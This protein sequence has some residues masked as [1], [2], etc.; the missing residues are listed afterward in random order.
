[1]NSEL[2]PTALINDGGNT[3]MSEAKETG[4]ESAANEEL[5]VEI[6][7]PED[8]DD[9]TAPGVADQDVTNAND[10]TACTVIEETEIDGTAAEQ[11]NSRKS[12]A[13]QNEIAAALDGDVFSENENVDGD[14][15]LADLHSF[16]RRAKSSKE[17]KDVPASAMILPPLATSSLTKK[18]PSGSLGSATSENGSPVS[19]I[20]KMATTTTT[21]MTSPR[22]PLGQKDANKSPSPSKKRKLKG[23]G[24]PDA[25]APLTKKSGGRLV[26]PDLEDYG[27][28]APAQ[29]KKRRRKI[30]AD[31]TGDIFNPDMFPSQ[32][33]TKRTS[34]SSSSAPDRD[35]GSASRRSSRIA[36]VKKT[37]AIP[38]RLPG[39]ATLDLGDMPAPSTATVTAR[40][41]DR[42]LAAQTRA[43]TDKN[44]G[45][46]MPVAFVLA[47]LGAA[48]ADED[49]QQTASITLPKTGMKSVRW[50]E[51]LARVQG[52]EMPAPA[53]AE[54]GE[55]AADEEE[56]MALPPPPQLRFASDPSDRPGNP[57]GGML[58]NEDEE[59]QGKK[60]A[61]AALSPAPVRR[62]ARSAA[63]R[64]PT[65]GGSATPVKKKS[66]L[67]S[68]GPGSVSKPSAAS[69]TEARARLGMAGP[70]TPGPRRGG[71]RR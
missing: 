65:R 64:L 59:E 67:P 1:M 45:G 49:D 12:D 38:V 17:R 43:N 69:A 31:R 10:R 44:K 60:D 68:A 30:E 8:V 6:H 41:A 5:E 50:D 63:S 55:G 9:I 52:E 20:E 54:N 53:A 11:D 24:P 58:A 23:S 56:E 62:S 66:S 26:A 3:V 40:K 36:T 32:D 61:P 33:L 37:A 70:G 25:A 15:A 16:V 57:V 28:E 35:G 21:T 48:V 2:Q 39:S 71:R 51:I 27:T 14:S 4:L 18:H 29:P 19:K 22:V 42:D 7:I 47:S 13:P 34:S 46:A